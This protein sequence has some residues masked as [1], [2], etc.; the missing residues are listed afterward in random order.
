MPE[1]FR[2]KLIAIIVGNGIVLSL[3]QYV[4]VNGFLAKKVARKKAS[5]N[6]KAEMDGQWVMGYTHIGREIPE[7]EVL[8]TK[9]TNPD[10]VHI[11]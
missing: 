8:R 9:Y 11:T 4:F 3:W 6:A 2:W 1:G 5:I 7:Y 10:I